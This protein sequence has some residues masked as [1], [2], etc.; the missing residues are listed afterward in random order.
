M[1]LNKMKMMNVVINKIKRKK[2]ESQNLK[3]KIK[4]ERIIFL[5]F[6]N[7]IFKLKNFLYY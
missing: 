3:K 1:K 7:S 2:K 6:F 5:I 4:N